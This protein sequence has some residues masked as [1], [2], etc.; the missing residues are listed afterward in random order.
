MTTQEYIGI[1]A[2]CAIGTALNVLNLVV[3]WAK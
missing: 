2:L 3:M 1:M